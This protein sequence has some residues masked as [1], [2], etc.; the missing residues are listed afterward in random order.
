M[1][2]NRDKENEKT[3]KDSGSACQIRKRRKRKRNYIDSH[4]GA[5]NVCKEV[6]IFVQGNLN[7]CVVK[8]LIGTGYSTNAVFGMSLFSILTYLLFKSRVESISYPDKWSNA[9]S[10]LGRGY[11]SFVVTSFSRW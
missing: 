9:S 6:G 3:K 7:R 4:V 5:N 8:L 11:A 10:M 2:K 1:L